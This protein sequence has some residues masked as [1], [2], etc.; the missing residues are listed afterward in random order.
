VAE[1][2]AAQGLAEDLRALREAAGC[3]YGDIIGF[4]RRQ[5]PAVTFSRASLSE[6]F[7]GKGVPADEQKF[8][9]LVEFLESRAARKDPGHQRRSPA[10]WEVLRWRAEAERRPV[11]A[12][13][14]SAGVRGAR[15]QAAPEATG[16]SG[17][18]TA[19]PDKPRPVPL[20]T[21]QQL[22][23]H[24]AIRGAAA[25]G[26]AFVLPDYVERGHDR[27]LRDLL[28]AAADGERA[29]MVVVR[30]GSC[31]GK[32]RTAFEGARACLSDWE[33]A[34]PKDV[35][36]LVALL[37]A[38]AVGPRTVLW[39][40]EAQEFLAGPAGEEAGAALRRLLEGPGPIVVMATLWPAEYQALTTN[41]VEHQQAR[42]VLGA[43][44]VVDVPDEFTPSELLVLDG[45]HHPS[46]EMAARTGALGAVTQTLAAGPQL[47]DHYD[48]AAPPHGPYGRAIVTAAMDA[49]R[50]GHTS[51]VSSA[52]LKEAASG[53]LTARQR[54][55]A[56][57]GTWFDGAL[58]YARKKV[59]D[60]ARALEPVADPG[61]MGSLPDVHRLSDFLDHHARAARRYAFPPDS[62]WTAAQHHPATADDLEA[63]GV[64]AEDRGRLRIAAALYQRAADAGKS[65]ALAGLAH[66]HQRAGD[67]ARA[68]TLFREAADHGISWAWQDLVH[69]QYAAGHGEEGAEAVL[70]E[71]VATAGDFQSRY[72]LAGQLERAGKRDEAEAMARE[73]PEEERFWILL[74]IARIREAHDDLAGAEAL[75]RETGE[76]GLQPLAMMYKRDGQLGAAEALLRQAVQ[77]GRTDALYDLAT[78]RF[79]A[80]DQAEAEE[81]T[82][83]AAA[84]GDPT[85]L[86]DLSLQH[87]EASDHRE[88]ER[89]ARLAGAAGQ[90]EPLLDLAMRREADRQHA[91]A[92]ELARAASSAGDNTALYELAI[93]R[94]KARDPS[95]AEQLAREAS[96]TGYPTALQD[97]AALRET[98]GDHAGADKLAHEAVAAGEPDIL[99]HVLGRLLE[100]GD[101]DGAEHLVL[102]AVNC[103]YPGARSELAMLRR[104]IDRDQDAA[105]RIE[106]FGLD[107]DGSPA[108][109]WP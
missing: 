109:R 93:L 55:D 98:G 50:L 63:L 74:D 35:G 79:E 94:E 16:A 90:P 1:G 91:A 26:E 6:W 40:N 101:R 29:V 65:R 62:F 51:P 73:A 75:L 45:L 67:L 3:S 12:P 9:L 33:L 60:V 96:A 32:T 11:Q 4:G 22:G 20:W 44:V 100:A 57:P 78:L 17:R 89:L 70:R 49:R 77:A 47:V 15:A 5:K 103:G 61:G 30:G 25:G 107:T 84:V 54:A 99:H 80:G 42:A 28:A 46:L 59:M 105:E 48:N 39:L 18:F 36:S 10:E 64:A 86:W 69:L 106:R 37:A 72:T 53:Y 68:E 71:A 66:L 83:Q 82:R 81:L 88:A 41:R 43:A 97:L 58:G 87:E 7:G 108:H 38:G 2:G 19:L 31:A 21:A 95:R 104:E 23:V 27:Q 52:F 92:E 14:V 24:P 34:F 85:A 56:D 102:D 13:K 76:A 8:E